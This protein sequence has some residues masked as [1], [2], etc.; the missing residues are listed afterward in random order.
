MAEFLK[1][2]YSHSIVLNK[3]EGITMP[4]TIGMTGGFENIKAKKFHV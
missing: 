4:E 1:S 2:V 3:K